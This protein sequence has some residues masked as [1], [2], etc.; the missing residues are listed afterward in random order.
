[1]KPEKSPASRQKGVMLLEALIAI[2]IFS[3][4]ILAMV[5]MQA[6]TINYVSDAKYRADASFI[7][8][9]I[10]GE[11]WVNRANLAT[12]GCNPCTTSNGNAGTQAWVTQMQAGGNTPLPGV[13][14]LA[15]QP[16]IVMG[17]VNNQVTVTVFWLP[18]KSSGPH[19]H[20]AI[21]YVNN[22]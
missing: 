11:M 6:N 13:T 7:A 22:P 8:N 18:P 21:A 10:I 3:M 17:A 15:N 4:G 16:R 2:L 14:N 1:M 20:T 9:K 5:G 12:Y 19:S